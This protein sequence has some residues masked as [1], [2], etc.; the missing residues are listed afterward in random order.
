MTLPEN[1]PPNPDALP[2]AAA[3]EA[4]DSNLP[5]ALATS[6]PGILI[7]PTKAELLARWAVTKPAFLVVDAWNFICQ[8]CESQNF[9]NN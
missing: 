5:D 9:R 6:A 7:I 1:T 8:H 4:S 2:V 3:G